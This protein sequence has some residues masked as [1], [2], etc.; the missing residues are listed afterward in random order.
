MF[1]AKLNGKERFLPFK[2]H[3]QLDSILEELDQHS[4][5]LRTSLTVL[6]VHNA[7]CIW[8]VETIYR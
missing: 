5:I 2:I 8:P 6:P 4:L 1:P 3:K 7:T